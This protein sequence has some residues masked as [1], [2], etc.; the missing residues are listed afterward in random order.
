MNQ[1]IRTIHAHHSVRSYT[2]AP[3]AE[4]MLEQV[5]EGGYRCPTSFN[6]QHV[7]VVVLR[8]PTTRARIAQLGGNQAWIARAP[9]F[10]TMVADL[11]KT[12]AGVRAAGGQ[13]VAHKSVELLV[14]CSI[15]AGI[16][17]G[18]MMTAARSLGLGVV[19]IGGIRRNPQ[20]MIELLKLPSLTFPLCGMCLGHIDEDGPRKPRLPM[21]TFRHDE[22]YRPEAI[23]AA[24]EPYDRTLMEHWKAVDR[25]DGSSW[26]ENLAEHYTKNYFPN[27]KPVIEAQGFT[28]EM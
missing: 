21:A 14:A 4:E 13:Q 24:I 15:D 19:P 27:V 2:D 26:S 28:H 17:L 9:V 11:N 25:A 7:S 8:S 1:T 12:M 20:A 10:I 3:V 5:I 22:F 18:N 23:E 16:A 6:A